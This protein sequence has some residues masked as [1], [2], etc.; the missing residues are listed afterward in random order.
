MPRLP[1]E[2]L[3]HILA[4]AFEDII[5]GGYTFCT[6]RATCHAFRELVDKAPQR[7]RSITVT[8]GQQ[9]HTLVRVL[10]CAP[11]HLINVEHLWIC[12]ARPVKKFTPASAGAD[13]ARSSVS[14]TTAR[15]NAR[16]DAVLFSTSHLSLQESNIETLDWMH[17]RRS[18][19]KLLTLCGP[20]LKSLFVA[21][22]MERDA[23]WIAGI[24]TTNYP[25]VQTL[26]MYITDGKDSDV[27][28]N[29]LMYAMPMLETMTLTG[30]QNYGN[31][32]PLIQ[33]RREWLPANVVQVGNGLRYPAR[34]VHIEGIPSSSLRDFAKDY[35]QRA[36]HGQPPVI[37]QTVHIWPCLA[38]AIGRVPDREIVEEA[39]KLSAEAEERKTIGV[40]TPGAIEVIIS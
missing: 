2:L 31:I 17:S 16:V 33:P 32:R 28:V 29:D 5:D 37:R 39:K 20:T 11:E 19:R 34:D 36:L 27:G 38:D 30:W 9:M 14:S 40:Q 10:E 15:V 18:V 8:G 13:S 6:L 26:D 7:F 23:L 21:F 35:A 12:D 24:N 4:Y 25:S 1:F 3:E 22:S